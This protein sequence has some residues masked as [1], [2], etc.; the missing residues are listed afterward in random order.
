MDK[1]MQQ[2]NRLS[3]RL[4]A[5]KIP[6]KVVGGGILFYEQAIGHV[7]CSKFTYERKWADADVIC[8]PGSYGYEDGLFE[9][10]GVELMTP[11]ECAEDDVVG[12][13][14]MEDVIAR[15]VKAYKEYKS[16]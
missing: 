10:R 4:N 7:F 8:K 9:I 11:E 6:H 5:L 16:K 12:F 14:T 13:L 15:I 1:G 3:E 2:I